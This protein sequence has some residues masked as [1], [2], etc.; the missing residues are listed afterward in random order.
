VVRLVPGNT[1]TNQS[2]PLDPAGVVY[3][4]T[5]RL[6]IGG[7]TVTLL[8][9][10]T[11]VPVSDLVGYPVGAT[12]NAQVTCGPVATATCPLPGAYQ[13]L[14]QPL[15]PAGDYT[16]AV[17]A[18][19]YQTSTTLLP[20]GSSYT[21]AGSAGSVVS[22][23][24]DN[25]SG[26]PPPQVGQDT[27][28]YYTFNLSPGTGAGVVNNHLPLD[29]SVLPALA[30]SKTGDRSQVELG[31]SLRY[32]V[33]VR[34]TDAGAGLLSS[35]ALVDT[36]P[37]GFKYI[38]GTVSVNNTPVAD[39]QVGLTQPGVTLP[40]FIN[41]GAPPLNASVTK[42]LA[43]KGSITV[44]Y[45]VRVGVGSMQGTGINRVQAKLS[46]TINCATTP[47]ACS[48]EAQF[49]VKVEGGVFTD[50]AC[51][52]GKVY[53]D[54]NHNQVQDP[55]ELGI[56]GVR[57][58]LIDGTSITSDVEGKYS[59][60]DLPPRT[61]VLKLDP[62]TLPKGSRLV[63]SSSRNA[64]D[65]GSL[66]LDP[67]NGEL[68]RSDFIEGSCSNTVLEQVKARRNQGEVGNPATGATYTEKKGGRV[69][70]FKGKAPGY[71]QEGTDSANQPLVKP[72]NEA[73]Q[74]DPAVSESE[75]NKPVYERNA[76]KLY[77]ANQGAGK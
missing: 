43:S 8:R 49:K 58:Y 38:P 21:P 2:L 30:V 16:I 46:P 61:S 6:S 26:N 47:L 48:N 11:P 55:E 34:R 36:L 5:T 17:T 52:A 18:P 9:N 45:R 35:F 42:G 22:I 33:V 13:F 62:L 73:G 68:V 23:N 39:A 27:T 40:M 74:S 50:Q 25:L 60:C 24:K 14:L 41:F 57:L 66:F 64:G 10:G 32:T 54:C 3:D 70:K 75:L 7:A 29:P 44:N 20:A 76:P 71:A 67:K 63:T 51:L 4:S 12:S 31:D 53:V 59:L 1:L 77:K 37:A 15:A 56:P 69:L 28:Y 72:R 65:A 19:N